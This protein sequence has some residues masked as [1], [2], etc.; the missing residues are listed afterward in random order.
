MFATKFITERLSLR[1]LTGMNVHLDESIGAFQTRGHILRLRGLSSCYS[2]CCCQPARSC[3][4]VPRRLHAASFAR[5][6]NTSAAIRKARSCV[7]RPTNENR[8]KKKKAL[9]I[10]AAAFEALLIVSDRRRNDDDVAGSDFD[11]GPSIGAGRFGG[12]N[13]IYFLVVL[14]MRVSERAKDRPSVCV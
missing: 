11:V 7:R 3:G 6:P 9:Q 8:K 1:L 4:I 5:R 14:D 2:C 13:V 10:R 12:G